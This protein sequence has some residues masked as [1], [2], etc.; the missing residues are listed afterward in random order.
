MGIQNHAP[1]LATY[2]ENI[3]FS[4]LREKVFGIDACSWLYKGVYCCVY[5]LATGIKTSRHVDFVMKRLEILEDSMILPVLVFD[6]KCVKLVEGTDMTLK[7]IQA[8]I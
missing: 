2:T 4:E 8:I 6:G 1:F 5:E 3:S 7:F